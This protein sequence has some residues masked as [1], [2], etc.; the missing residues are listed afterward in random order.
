MGTQRWHHPGVAIGLI[1]GVMKDK[2][3]AFRLRWMSPLLDP[4]CQQSSLL[5]SQSDMPLFAKRR[6]AFSLWL[7]TLD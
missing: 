7:E 1:P 2:R 3:S 4:N 6:I 5:T